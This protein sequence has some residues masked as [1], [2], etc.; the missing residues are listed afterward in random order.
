MKSMS[1]NKINKFNDHILQIKNELKTIIKLSILARTL[2]RD[3]VSTQRFRDCMYMMDYNLSTA[4]S[5][6]DEAIKDV[7]WVD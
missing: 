6:R 5:L 3:Y 1:Q 2:M 7:K 4:T